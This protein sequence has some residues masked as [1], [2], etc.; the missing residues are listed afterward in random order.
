MVLD[1]QEVLVS[2]LEQDS[3]EMGDC[4]PQIIPAPWGKGKKSD[5]I[6]KLLLHTACLGQACVHS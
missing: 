2:L 6:L 3:R 4:A 1:S 5:G